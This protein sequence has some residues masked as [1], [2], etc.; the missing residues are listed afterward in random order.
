MDLA[1]VTMPFEA[2]VGS[3][4]ELVEV[5]SDQVD[6]EMLLASESSGI[7]EALQGLF[8][9]DGNP[10]PDEVI[11]LGRSTWHR[12]T[13]TTRIHVYDERI[14][15]WHA[16]LQGR[17]LYALARATR[18]VYEL[19]FNADLTFGDI[20][21]FVSLAGK[22]VRVPEQLTRFTM[23]RVS[24]DHWLRDS[25]FVGLFHH[26]YD[27]R[28]IVRGDGSRTDAFSTYARSAPPLSALA[29][30]RRAAPPRSVPA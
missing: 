24:E 16:D 26:V 14:W 30:R 5:R 21:P 20:V 27:L 2:S 6:R 12:E 1:A 13:S 7:P 8:W 29:V 17:G 19:R 9:M 28:R 10:L 23:R 3:D 15:S 25:W 22:R 11:S 4:Y 18:L